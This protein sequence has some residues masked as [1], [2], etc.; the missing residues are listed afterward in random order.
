MIKYEMSAWRKGKK[1]N[2]SSKSF[3]SILEK[4]NELIEK[5]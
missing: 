5:I 2:F 1:R 4:A 3:E